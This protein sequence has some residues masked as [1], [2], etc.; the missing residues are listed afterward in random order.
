M[1]VQAL[2]PEVMNVEKRSDSGPHPGHLR[3][4]VTGGDGGGALKESSLR[5]EWYQLD[6]A[7][8]PQVSSDGS[9]TESFRLAK[10]A[11]HSVIHFLAIFSQ[12]SS[13]VA[14]FLWWAPD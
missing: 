14:L 3:S 1:S 6:A 2:S 11:P 4:V 7:P 9:K 13:L 12:C 5:L 10:P 8:W